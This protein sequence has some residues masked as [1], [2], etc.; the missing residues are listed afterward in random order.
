MY[1]LVKVTYDY[2]RFQE[3]IAASVDHR[4]ICVT[5]HAVNKD[6]LPIC[7]YKKDD[8]EQINLDHDEIAHL[9]IQTL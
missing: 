3:N 1:V 9:W 6:S 4:E 2:Y 5:A 7:A 8:A